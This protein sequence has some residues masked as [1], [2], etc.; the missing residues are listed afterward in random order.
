MLVAASRRPDF[1]GQTDRLLLNVAA[2][3]AALGL[4]EAHLL[5]AQRRLAGELDRRVADRTRELALANAELTKEVGERRVVED[6]LRWE[7]RELKQS[8]ARKAAILDSALECIVT[9]DHEGRITEFNPAA[10]RTFGYSRGQAVGSVLAD[11]IVPPEQREAHRL[12]F[13]RY[14]ATGEGQVL[15]RRLEMTAMRADGSEFPV[16]LAIPGSR[17]TGR[18]RSRDICGTSPSVRRTRTS[19]RRS[20]AFLAEAQR[21]SLTGSF[22][23]RVPGDE[24]SWSEQLYR[25]FAFEPASPVT[26]DRIASRLHPDDSRLLE[27]A[28][29]SRATDPGKD[30]S[31]STGSSCL[32]VPSAPPPGGPCHP[33]HPESWSTSARCRT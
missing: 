22:S 27:T 17:S 29:R 7:E 30:S 16:E 28:I 13:A 8:E 10:E 12:G 20:E 32:T 25:I 2:N 23:W 4:R 18:R 5:A 33:A 11:T 26:L 1:P 9:I 15:G 3:H 31:S 19:M 6:R 21:L 14:L 24:I